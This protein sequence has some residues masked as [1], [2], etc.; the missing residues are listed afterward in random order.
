[1]ARKITIPKETL[2]VIIV[3]LGILSIMGFYSYFNYHPV[4]YKETV[5]LINGTFQGWDVQSG[6]NNPAFK[7]KLKEYNA[8]FA[9]TRPFLSVM[10]RGGF[11]TLA[12]KGDKINLIVS[13]KDME[14]SSDN[15]QCVDVYGISDQ[16]RV[17]LSLANLNQ[18]RFEE[19]FV[20]LIAGYIFLLLEV[21]A[22]YFVFRVSK[23]Q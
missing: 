19:A 7:I 6:R 3:I 17:Y 21:I 5:I 2:W 16:S 15:C 4:K 10:D 18:S 22:I 20:G 12:K 1:M 8:D 14:N 23:V 11:I 13:K 9:V